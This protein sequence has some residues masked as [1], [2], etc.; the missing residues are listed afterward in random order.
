MTAVAY[1]A[2]FEPQKSILPMSQT[3]WTWGCSKQNRQ[4][5]SDVY[6]TVAATP[7]VTRTPG[8]IPNTEYEKGKDMIAKQMYSEN[9]SAAVYIGLNDKNACVETRRADTIT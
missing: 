5:T 2:Q 4:R 6:W 7:M 1:H 8:T 3:L 9:S